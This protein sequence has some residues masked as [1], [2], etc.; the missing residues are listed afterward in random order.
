M[1][2][3][4]NEQFLIL[5]FTIGLVNFVAAMSPGPD[6]LLIM[7]SVLRRG[8]VYAVRVSIG[9]G[10]GIIIHM[11][12]MLSGIIY[13]LQ[14]MPIILQIIGFAGAVYLSYLGYQCFRDTS[15]FDSTA[16]Y[17]DNE[18]RKGL[19]KYPFIMGFLTNALNPKAFV[20]FLGV[21]APML[22]DKT[23]V[24]ES[25]PAMIFLSLLL[26][27]SVGGWFILLSYG[28]G[29][30]RFIEWFEDNSLLINKI[31]GTVFSVYALVMLSNAITA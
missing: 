3:L 19:E 16:V 13:L 5:A 28:V 24:F 4:Y 8:F 15:T 21:A 27:I 23:Y 10:S 25:M 30:P 6:T 20:F 1:D 17:D 29:R 9:V 2:I 26:A 31:V 22:Q 18:D 12:V 11:V 14:T 7:R